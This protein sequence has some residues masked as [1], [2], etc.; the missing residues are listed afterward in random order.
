MSYG[1]LRGPDY[2]E[3]TGEDKVET[4]PRRPDSR[5]CGSFLLCLTDSLR[6]RPDLLR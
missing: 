6:Q 2:T 4:T 5:R 3:E 1:R